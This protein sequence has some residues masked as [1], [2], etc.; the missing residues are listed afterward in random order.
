MRDMPEL[1]IYPA[2]GA[3]EHPSLALA[4]TRVTLP[5]GRYVDELTTPIE[6]TTWLINHKLAP[7]GAELQTYCQSRLIGL[8][9]DLR[10]LFSTRAA[11]VALDPKSLDGINRALASAPHVSLLRHDPHTGFFRSTEHPVTQV[12]EHAMSLIAE[13][14]AE[15]LTDNQ[16]GL[17]AQC[18]SSPCVR[19]YVRTHARR[20][21]CSIRCGDR[22]R[23]ARAYARKHGPIPQ[24]THTAHRP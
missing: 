3:D 18:E 23:A 6:A 13:D 11:G 21:W 1:P 19:F 24:P 14:A 22:V 9:D 17:I 20:Q 16:E 10:A 8:R 2:P 4:N 12:V 5:G 15:L 7:E